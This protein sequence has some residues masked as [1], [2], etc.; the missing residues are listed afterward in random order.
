MKTPGPDHPITLEKA[1]NRWRARYA[2]HVIADTDDAIILREADYP[3]VVY[4][5][6]IDVEM[7]Y[8]SRT[9]RGTHCP[10][11]GDASYFT[12][13]MDGQFAE[14]AVWTY[15]QPFPA[16][17]AIEGRL[18]FYP[19]KIEVYEVADEAVNPHHR[20]EATARADEGY[21]IG[22]DEVVQHTDSGAGAPQ[23]TPWPTN[24]STPDDGGL[25]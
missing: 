20:P 21:A 23:R 16:M 2:G 8:M 17:E 7:G 10:Y 18:A 14:N 4:F 6:R 15:E 24:V 22:V 12:V 25:R 1:A 13:L 3:P 5:P 11:K 9:A 19:D